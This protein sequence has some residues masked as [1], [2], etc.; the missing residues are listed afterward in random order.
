VNSETRTVVV[1]DIH[2]GSRHCYCESFMR[3]IEAL[4]DGVE[5]VLNG[6]VID[7]WHSTLK[8]LHAEALEQLRAASERRH[9][10]WVRGNHDDQYELADPRGIVSVSEYA[11]G[12]RLFISHG[13]DFDNIMPY[14]RGF[15]I[16]FRTFHRLRIRLGAESVHVAR[17]AKK[18]RLLYGALRKHVA[19]NAV[20]H[21]RENGFAAV[22]CGHTHYAEDTIIDGIRYI[23]TG[24]WTEKPL[25]CLA[26]VEDGM[27]L[28]TVP[29]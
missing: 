15:I 17:Y 2:L 9:V 12:K 27:E 26:L 21:A 20:E 28:H 11:I 25:Y 18:F 8:G 6:D 13:F 5:L 14:H 3:F 10:V 19:M 7:H 16:L 1:S 29:E 24:A 4:P 22:T 23:N